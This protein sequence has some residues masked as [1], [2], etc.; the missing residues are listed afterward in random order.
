MN[1]RRPAECNWTGSTADYLVADCGEEGSRGTPS[2]K[3][4]TRIEID[5]E[6]SNAY[7]HVHSKFIYLF[8]ELHTG[9]NSI[10]QQSKYIVQ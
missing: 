7:L 4:G 3:A 6:Y 9:K 5:S 8:M 10:K 2:G 1:D